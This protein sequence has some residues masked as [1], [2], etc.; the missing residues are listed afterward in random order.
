MTAERCRVTAVQFCDVTDR[1][2][3]QNLRS[4]APGLQRFMYVNLSVCGPFGS[5]SHN[6]RGREKNAGDSFSRVRVSEFVAGA[7]GGPT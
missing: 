2:T 7:L 1:L 4:F 5:R 3:D 6:V